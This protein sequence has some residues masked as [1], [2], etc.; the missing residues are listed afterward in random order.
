MNLQNLTGQTLG[1]YELRELLGMGGMGAVYKGYQH[2][3]KRYVAVKVLGAQFSQQAGAIERFNREAETSAVLEHPVLAELLIRS[4]FPRRLVFGHYGY[5]WLL[6][7]GSRHST[8][9]RGSVFWL[10][11]PGT[12]FPFLTS[13]HT[14]E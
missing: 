12:F 1:Q 9:P 2:T 3:L 8:S 13:I 14:E 10:Y 5:L 7:Q 11:R 6:Q 4:D